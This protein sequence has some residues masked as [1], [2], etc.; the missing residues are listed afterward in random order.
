[1]PS[2]QKCSGEKLWASD[3]RLNALIQWAE[4]TPQ[5]NYRKAFLTKDVIL[6]E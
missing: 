2:L 6:L 5:A 1:M 4:G 3:S